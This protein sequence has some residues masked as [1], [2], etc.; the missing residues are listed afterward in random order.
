MYRVV[1]SR[2]FRKALVKLPANRQKRILGKIR[3]VAANP[4]APNNNPTG[5]QGT[6]G[7][8]FR[9]GDWRVIYELDDNRFVMLLLEVGSRGGIY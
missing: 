2:P 5:L 4:Y 7:H 9:V 6:E 1:R 3:E 8:R